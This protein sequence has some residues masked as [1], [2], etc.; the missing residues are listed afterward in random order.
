MIRA[1]VADSFSAVDAPSPVAEPVMIA[2]LSLKL[3]MV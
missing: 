3:A 1:P 2:T